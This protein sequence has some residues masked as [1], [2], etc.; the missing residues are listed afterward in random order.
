MQWYEGCFGF[1]FWNFFY[2]D[3]KTID[4]KKLKELTED[5]FDKFLEKR[6]KD[7]QIVPK[8]SVLHIKTLGTQAN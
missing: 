2:P 5:S 3:V 1:L 4:A 6:L 7:G 8:G